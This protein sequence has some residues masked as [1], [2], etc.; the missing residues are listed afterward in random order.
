M[1]KEER[2]TRDP[3]TRT[4]PMSR[5]DAR[6]VR[7]PLPLP[8]PYSAACTSATS[9][10]AEFPVTARP[11]VLSGGNRSALAFGARYGVTHDMVVS[12]GW[13][14]RNTALMT[15]PACGVRSYVEE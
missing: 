4:A 8:I 12:R 7:R 13:A 9:W 3:R 15:L 2:L 10:L 14:P 6:P 1:A 11:D 5:R